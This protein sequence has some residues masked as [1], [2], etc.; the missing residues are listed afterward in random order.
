[1]ATGLAVVAP[2][3][4]GPATYVK[5]GLTG[6][7]ADTASAESVRAALHRAGAA[8]SDEP[9]ARRTSNL[10]RSMYTI[11]AMAQSLAAVYTDVLRESD[12]VAA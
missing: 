2:G 5:E 9:R 8:R 7:L 1:M 4:G 11:E 10:V 12:Q 6:F 3:S